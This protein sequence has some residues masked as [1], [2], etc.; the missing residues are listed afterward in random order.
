M[1][2]QTRQHILI[3]LLLLLSGVTASWHHDFDRR[4]DVYVEGTADIAVELSYEAESSRS[5]QLPRL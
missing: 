4:A 1:K 2:S 3:W 5:L